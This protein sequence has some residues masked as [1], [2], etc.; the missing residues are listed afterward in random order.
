MEQ[1]LTS[2][3]LGPTITDNGSVAFEESIF[4]LDLSFVTFLTKESIITHINHCNFHV[5]GVFKILN[6][7][8]LLNDNKKLGKDA[9]NYKSVVGT[10]SGAGNKMIRIPIP[11][12]ANLLFQRGK[13]RKLLKLYRSLY[14]METLT[15]VLESSNPGTGVK[16]KNTN[17]LDKLTLY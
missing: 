2:K 5:L 3:I 8:V 14:S 11:T 9:C 4:N 13:T 10:I 1:S 16:K 12:Y 15:T 17:L 7:E 6:W